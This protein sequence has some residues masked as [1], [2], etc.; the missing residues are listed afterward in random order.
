MELEVH[1]ESKMVPPGRTSRR[2][3][4]AKIDADSNGHLSRGR[5]RFMMHVINHGIKRNCVACKAVGKCKIMTSRKA[6]KALEGTTL[7]LSVFHRRYLSCLWGSTKVVAKHMRTRRTTLQL[8][9]RTNIDKSP[10]SQNSPH[11]HTH[12]YCEGDGDDGGGGNQR[13]SGGVCARE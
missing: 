3:N 2:Q 7:K 13:S 4:Q 10:H 6:N 8:V 9:T 12:P 11:I 1:L 5:I